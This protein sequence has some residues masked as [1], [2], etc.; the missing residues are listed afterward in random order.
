MSEICSHSHSYLFIKTGYELNNPYD[1]LAKVHRKSGLFFNFLFL[2]VK[3]KAGRSR[4]L[5]SG[6]QRGH[7]GPGCLSVCFSLTT[8]LGGLPTLSMIAFLSYLVKSNPE[9]IPGA[10]L[11]EQAFLPPTPLPQPFPLQKISLCF[12]IPWFDSPLSP[13]LQEGAFLSTLFQLH[14]ILPLLESIAEI[15][16]PVSC[17][18]HLSQ[19]CSLLSLRRTYCLPCS[20]DLIDSFDKYLL[21]T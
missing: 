10:L 1:S 5:L 14:C 19:E 12:P 17:P 9:V 6:A 16:R 11:T 18:H 20:V 8:A 7:P 15:P 13:Y 2:K 21:N 3:I 4:T